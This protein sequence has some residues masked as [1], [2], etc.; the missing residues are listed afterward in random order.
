MQGTKARPQAL[1]SIACLCICCCAE[2]MG[3]PGPAMGPVPAFDGEVS[4][5]ASPITASVSNTT[6]VPHHA[7]KVV[8]LKVDP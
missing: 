1:L 7:L 4:F 5:G 8:A 2:R 3:W 6:D